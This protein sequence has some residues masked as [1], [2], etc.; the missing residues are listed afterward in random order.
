MKLTF[1]GGARQVTGSMYLLELDDDYRIL[2]DCGIDQLRETDRYIPFPPELT[3]GGLFPFEPSMINLVVLTHAHI[4]HSGNLPN[5]VR[6]GYEGQIIC[7]APTQQLSRLLLLDSAMLNRKKLNKIQGTGKRRKTSTKPSPEAEWLYLERHAENAV[8]S[9]ITIPFNHRFKIKNG[10][11]LTFIPTGHL[12]GAANVLLEINEGGQWKRIG[13]SGDI[14]RANYPLLRDPEPFPQVDVL[15]TE[16]TYGNRNHRDAGD[17]LDILEPIIRESC[18]DVPGRLI[19]PAFSVGRTQALL[20]T[21][22]RLYQERDFPSIKVFADSPLALKSTQVYENYN[23]LLNE[24]AQQF[25]ATYGALFD[26]PNLHYIE[27]M[28]ESRALSNHNEPSIIISSSGM[29]SGGRVEYHVRQNIG[30]PYATIL[31]I[32]Y[33][34]EGTL[35]RRL[36]DGQKYLRINDKDVPVNAKIRQTDIFSGHAGLD[37]LKRFVQFQDADKVKQ[38][39]LVHGEP[40]SM[41]DF[42][43]TLRTMGYEDI[44]LP[45]KGEEFEV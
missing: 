17:P 38:I 34:A 20:Y 14:G 25:R 22:N 31:M 7:T 26:F 16:S 43:L 15:V 13:F 29:V 12:L 44:Y 21:L 37:D 40:A 18:I 5:L 2:I 11:Y 8:E 28:R 10:A 41:T 6:E 24:E 23:G 27:N 3:H 30:N 39:F 19:I 45:E 1:W 32:G 9:F 35:G 36:L 4:D 42:A 33:S